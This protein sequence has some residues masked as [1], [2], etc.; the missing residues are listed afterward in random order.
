MKRVFR[1]GFLVL[2]VLF[3]VGT[4]SVAFSQEKK[5]WTM[6]VYLNGDNNLES[7]AYDD[8]HEMEKV[9]S[10]DFMNVVVQFDSYETADG[11]KRFLIK[12]NPDASVGN[13]FLARIH[14]AALPSLYH[15]IGREQP[16]I[17]SAE[18]AKEDR[19]IFSPLVEQ[20]PELDMGDWK[21][22][23]DFVIWGMEK[24]PA[25]HYFVVL[26]NHGSGWSKA[27]MA[28]PLR[29]ISYDDTDGGHITT[30]ELRMAIEE[31]YDKTQNKIEMLGFDACLMQ[32][33]EVM[34]EVRNFVHVMVASEETEPGPGWPYDFFLNAI[35]KT[36]TDKKSSLSP[37]EIGTQLVKTYKDS[38]NGGSQ[39]KDDTTLSA[40]DLEKLP[41]ALEAI[42]D[43]ALSIIYNTTIDKENLK[44][45]MMKTQKYYDRDYK[46]LYHFAALLMESNNSKDNH[47]FAEETL[48]LLKAI[49]ELVFAND[50][51]GSSM[52]NSHGV[53]IHMPAPAYA[54]S[55]V[56][57][58]KDE[59]KR[60]NYLELEFAKVSLWDEFLDFLYLDK[61]KK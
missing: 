28:P 31:I 24:Y 23:R 21:V 16:S 47:R 27:L 34:T 25:Q 33:M 19:L 61:G 7:A 43:F 42:N 10:N 11:V 56:R 44:S 49:Q 35:L 14:R 55:S 53:S 46:D 20:L 26:W 29:G 59:E 36:R 54:G 40:V 5:E 50:Y 32:M 39:G 41:P 17:Q 15:L 8:I 58:G 12:K 45:L 51:T 13:K 1:A 60:K 37:Q 3:A 22:F 6:L 52:K 30:P 57:W 9:G 18:P 48:R 4:T 2:V 38:Y